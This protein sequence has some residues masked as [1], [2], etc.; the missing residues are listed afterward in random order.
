MPFVGKCLLGCQSWWWEFSKWRIS[1]VSLWMCMPHTQ[2]LLSH[3]WTNPKIS[4]AE[5]KCPAFFLAFHPNPL[6]PRS[7]HNPSTDFHE[8]LGP[9]VSDRV[10]LCLKFQHDIG[11][12]FCWHQSQTG[13]R[14]LEDVFDWTNSVPESLTKHTGRL[15]TL[16]LFTC[17]CINGLY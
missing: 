10:E 5:L 4:K 2:I 1:L 13:W 16:S 7:S 11:H 3:T 14:A 12:V 9:S 15:W 17:V 6:K 8:I